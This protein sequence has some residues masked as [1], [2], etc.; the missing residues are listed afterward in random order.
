MKGPCF[1][2]ERFDPLVVDLEGLI[3]V[4]NALEGLAA[5][6]ED[7]SQVGQVAHLQL[8][9]GVGAVAVQSRVL[10]LLAVVLERLFV[11]VELINPVVDLASL[12]KLLGLKQC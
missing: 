10:F 2:E 4:G 9:Q 7:K 8:L 5:F 1:P 6:E 11:R 12:I 3:T